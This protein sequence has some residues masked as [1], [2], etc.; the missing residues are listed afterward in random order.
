M[1]TSSARARLSQQLARCADTEAPLDRAAKNQSPPDTLTDEDAGEGVRQ[2][3][4][5]TE[6]EA[7]FLP[8]LDLDPAARRATAIDRL[9]ILRDEPLV[10]AQLD[11]GPGVESVRIEPASRADQRRARAGLLKDL[12][13]I[14]G[15]RRRRAAA[16]AVSPLRCER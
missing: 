5:A 16:R 10:A 13:A 15:C 9:G 8:H 12:P 3:E 4:D 11:L 1:A 14:S 6:D 2:A 7:T